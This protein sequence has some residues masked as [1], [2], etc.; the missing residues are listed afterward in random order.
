MKR[1]DFWIRVPSKDR[2][3]FRIYERTGGKGGPVDLMTLRFTKML[4]GRAPMTIGRH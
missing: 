4:E 2:K 3:T 1:K